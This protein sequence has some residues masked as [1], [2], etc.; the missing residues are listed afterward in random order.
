MARPLKILLYA[1][2]ALAALFII[3]AVSFVLLFDPNDFKDR[4]AQETQKATGRELV[5]EGDLDV[6]RVVSNEFEMEWPPRSGRTQ[7]FP[8]VDQAAWLDVAE[9]ATKINAA[10]VPL[11]EELD[12]ILAGG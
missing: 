12:R 6:S 1:V 4:I 2:G 9:A 5:I 11:L 3:A 8:G 7:R 10:Q